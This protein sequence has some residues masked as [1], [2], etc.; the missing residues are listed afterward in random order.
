MKQI[1]TIT[2][3]S[4]S[5]FLSHVESER[6]AEEEKGNKADFIFRGQRTDEP[7]LPR[8]ARNAAKG[9]LLEIEQLMFEEFK[10]TSP[11]LTELNPESRWDFLALAQ[12]HRLPTRL[13]DWT[14]SALAGLWFAVEKEPKKVKHKP[15]NAVVWLLKTKVDDFVD[16]SERKSPFANGVTRIYRPRV[17]TRRIAVQGGVFTVHKVM[18]GESFV[19]LERNKRFKRRLIKFVIPSSAFPHIREHLNGCGVNR[20]SLFPDLDGLCAHLAWRYIRTGD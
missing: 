5:E 6:K 13:L 11:A 17:I 19:A 9:Q 3:N 15:R 2:V 1:R 10:R 16:E 14:Y 20:F 4:L 8:L 12:H 7:L 18:K